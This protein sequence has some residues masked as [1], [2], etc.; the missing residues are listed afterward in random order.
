[1]DPEPG[2]RGDRRR[3]PGG[4]SQQAAEAAPEPPFRLDQAQLP[5]PAAVA[6]SPGLD[7]PQPPAALAGVTSGDRHRRPPR[8]RWSPTGSFPLPGAESG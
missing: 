5:G 6:G 7:L 8:P 3:H 1:M 2:S 4:P